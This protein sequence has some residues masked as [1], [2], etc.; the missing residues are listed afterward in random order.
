MILRDKNKKP[1]TKD[2]KTIDK[3]QESSDR[4][5]GTIYC[6]AKKCNFSPF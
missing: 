6:M 4:G 5:K 1:E 3:D 2:K